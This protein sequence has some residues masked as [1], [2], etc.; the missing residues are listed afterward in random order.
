MRPFHRAT[1][2]LAATAAALLSAPAFAS[3][4]TVVPQPDTPC[5]QN[6]ADAMTRV[7]NEKTPLV[8]STQQ[9][10]GYQWTTVTSPYPISDRW[11]SYGPEL[12]LHG[13]GMRNASI[14]SGDWT[15][16]PQ[17]SNTPCR[18]WQVAV[19]AAGVVGAPQTAE[20][21]PGQPLSFQVLPN[22]F[23]IKLSGY[24]LWVKAPA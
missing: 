24:C 5:S 14:R 3:A 4:D 15:G 17:D 6:F 13:Q 22:L 9:N 12:T 21:A 11:L 8:C 7:P 16:F 10:L 20:G 23:T 1:A 18:V 2:T 19:V